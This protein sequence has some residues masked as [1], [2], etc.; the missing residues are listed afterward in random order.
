MPS[1]GAIPEETMNA[2]PIAALLAQIDDH[3]V[4]PADRAFVE[5]RL[6]RERALLEDPQ[7]LLA[8][9][10]RET[11]FDWDFEPIH[12]GFLDLAKPFLERPSGAGA[13]LHAV[14]REYGCESKGARH[15]AV[16]LEYAHFATRINDHF[17]YHGAFADKTPDQ[18]TAERLVQ[19]RYGAQWLNNYPRWLIVTNELDVAPEVRIGVHRWGHRS[20]TAT[21]IARACFVRF[22]HR[23]F[24][25]VTRGQWL[26]I[27]PMLLCELVISPAAMATVLVGRSEEDLAAVKRAFSHLSVAVKLRLER[28]SLTDFREPDDAPEHDVSLPMW[29][30][31]SVV[32]ADRLAVDLAPLSGTRFPRVKHVARALARVAREGCRVETLRTMRDEELQHVRLFRDELTRAHLLPHAAQSF[33]AAFEKE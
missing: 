32:A 16:I 12:A 26:A 9:V 8:K 19:L 15:A 6:A 24:S 20:F 25:G 11:E 27:A 2:S 17:N 10:I 1:P 5:G 21:G 22:A 23:G 28:K 14:L 13:L 30:P 4:T 3:Y 18:A 29:F 7:H 31:G 33:S